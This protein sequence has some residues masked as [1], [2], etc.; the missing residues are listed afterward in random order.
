MAR[1]S[2]VAA[3]DAS[4]TPH[5]QPGEPSPL[6]VEEVPPSPFGGTPPRRPLFPQRPP[7]HPYRPRHPHG[8]PSAS[9]NGRRQVD[10]H[11]CD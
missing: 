5:E 9:Y 8:S 10:C 11:C 2:P 6:D 7:P 1:V 3:G 4:P